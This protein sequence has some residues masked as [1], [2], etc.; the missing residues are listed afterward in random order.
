[1]DLSKP[2]NYLPDELI[3]K[4]SVLLPINE[5]CNFSTISIRFSNLLNQ[6]FWRFKFLNDFGDQD[7]IVCWKNAY[8]N[9][10]LTVSFGYNDEG[11][12]GLGNHKTRNIP[13]LIPN[14][15]FKSVACGYHHA[16]GLDLNNN[17]WSFGN[18]DVGQLGLGDEDGIQDS[19]VPLQ[20]PNIKAKIIACGYEH[21][22]IT[23]L[24]DNILGFGN[25]QEDQLGEIHSNRVYTPTKMPY[26]QKAKAVAC[27]I[28][29]SLTIDLSNNVWDYGKIDHNDEDED[30]TNQILDINGKTICCAENYSMIIDANDNLFK[31]EIERL[32]NIYTIVQIILPGNITKFKAV[33]CCADNTLVIDINDNVWSLNSQKQVLWDIESKA[34]SISCGNHHALLIDINDNV[35]SFGDNYRG[36]L[37]LGDYND[38][39]NPCCIMIDEIPIK[40]RSIVCGYDYSFILLHPNN[41]AKYKTHLSHIE[42]NRQIY[43][44][45]FLNNNI[46]VN[47][48]V[49]VQF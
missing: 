29:N 20:I 3:I 42:N 7:E 45:A 17:V 18:N 14:I 9:Y 15:R 37:G 49:I 2:F 27:G 34:K 13:T 30:F 39:L 22:M 35:W 48:P 36:Q 5:I 28:D 33:S 21:S 10:G 46:F 31:L 8:Q 38:R 32:P 23:D 43:P 4:I 44:N 11:Q 26:G 24:D 19:Y 16:L 1:M 25:N 41:Q 47:L 6:Q 40:A 12:L